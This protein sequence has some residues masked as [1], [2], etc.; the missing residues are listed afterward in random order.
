VSGLKVA[1]IPLAQVDFETLLFASALATEF[2]TQSETWPVFRAFCRAHYDAEGA[3][4]SIEEVG[5][6]REMLE[7][8]AILKN[9]TGVG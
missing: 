7:I 5:L 3:M 4:G 1:Q 6:R 8:L 9:L 2:V